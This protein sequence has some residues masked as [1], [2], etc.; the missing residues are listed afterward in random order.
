M[1]EVVVSLPDDL[2]A[3]IDAEATARASNRST[4]VELALRQGL[5]RR[6]PEAIDAAMARSRERFRDGEKVDTTAF[7]R[8]D[9][10]RLPEWLSPEH[11]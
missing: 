10:D 3:E 7:I 8:A 4:V 6:D 1:A 2:L 9:R 5:H 11:R